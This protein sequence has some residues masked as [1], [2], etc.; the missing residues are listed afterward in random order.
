MRI[1]IVFS[2]ALVQTLTIEYFSAKF[3][4]LLSF[5]RINDPYRLLGLLLL[6]LLVTLPLFI[7]SYGLTWPELTGF[8]VGEKISE[9]LTPYSELVDSTP[10]LTQWLYGL[11]DIIAGRSLFGRHLLAFLVLFFQ[12]CYL[13]MVFI[14]KKAFTENT[15]IPSVIF[16][17]LCFFSFDV[18][19]MSG[20]LLASGFLLLAINS[21][22]KEIEFRE[23]N[24]ET[25][26]K[27]GFYL[28]LASLSVF[29]YVLFFFSAQLI[30]LFFTRSSVRRQLLFFTGFLL[31]HVLLASWYFF[32]DNQQSLWSN[33]YLANIQGNEVQMVSVKTLFVLLS[34]PLFYFLVSF[35]I[36]NRSVR[37]TNYQSQLLQAMFLWLIAGIIH[38]FFTRSLRPQSML[39]LFPP[40]SFLLAHFLLAIRR[41]RFAEFHLWILLLGVLLTSNLT[42]KNYF[43]G[44]GYTSLL[45]PEKEK[46]F[47]GKRLLVLANDVSLFTDN[48]LATGLSEWGL[49]RHLFDQS[50]TY[51][52]IIYLRQQLITDKPEVIIDP[53]NR[54]QAF[55]KHV[56]ELNKSYSKQGNVYFLIEK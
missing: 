17:I 16:I 46:E 18:I 49:T 52:N 42:R 30:L 45:V 51:E 3:L 54:M 24:D 26:L 1:A 2:S 39:P 5:F 41:K 4:A 21:L 10:L 29:S 35:F 37:L 6:F 8:I 15:Y 40:L 23:P 22:F 19:S 50:T 47:S 38:L 44:I 27:I 20:T 13:G 34:V 56:P 53:D 43:S 7:Y 31:P 32:F 48:S 28:S 36:L 55:F 33:F 9:G 25:L 11:L 14:N 12:A